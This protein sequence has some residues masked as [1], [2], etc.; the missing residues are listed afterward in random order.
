MV[1]EARGEERQ[2]K[3]NQYANP[4]KSHKHIHFERRHAELH[5]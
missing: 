2:D 1:G 5:D 4:L 3:S